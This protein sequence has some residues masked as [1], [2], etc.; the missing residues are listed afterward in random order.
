MELLTFNY[1][2]IKSRKIYIV[3]LSNF[4][5]TASTKNSLRLFPVAF[6]FSFVPFGNTPDILSLFFLCSRLCFCFWLFAFFLLPKVVQIL[7]FLL[8]SCLAPPQYIYYIM[9]VIMS[10]IIIFIM[11]MFLFI[12]FLHIIG[13]NTILIVIMYNTMHNFAIV[14]CIYFMYILQR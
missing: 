13:S 9:F 12:V 6:I 4:S 5:A 14:L 11:Y 10:I 7:F 3:S 1:Y 8:L 2:I